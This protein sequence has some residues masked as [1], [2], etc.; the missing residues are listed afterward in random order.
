M[1]FANDGVA[2]VVKSVAVPSSAQR[3]AGALASVLTLVSLLMTIEWSRRKNYDPARYMGGVNFHSQLF[4][5]HPILMVFG[6]IFCLMNSMLAYRLLPFPKRTSKYVHAAL[7]TCTIICIALGLAT[8]VHSKNY[9]NRN[10]SHGYEPGFYSVHSIIGII[11]ISTYSLNFLFG[12]VCFLVPGLVSKQQKSSAR[13]YHVFSGTL[14]LFEAVASVH[15][16]IMNWNSS[17]GCAVTVDSASW[18]PAAQYPH[19][20]DGCKLSNGIG[21]VVLCAVF[22]ASYALFGPAAQK[23]VDVQRY[24]DAE[25]L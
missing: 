23:I 17:N 7:H 8:V 12:V 4:S 1:N 10:R 2:V 15:S 13:P 18:D 9:S 11:A 19:L 20:Q 3:C 6:M 24:D 25:Y 14:I 5:M 22:C 16:G 21:V